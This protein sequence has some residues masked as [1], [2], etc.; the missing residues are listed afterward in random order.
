MRASARATA[1]ARLL[2]ALALGV[3]G[4]GARPSTKYHAPTFD[5]GTI[6]VGSEDALVSCPPTRATQVRALIGPDVS[7]RVVCGT[8]AVTEVPLATVDVEG[9]GTTSWSATLDPDDAFHLPR[10]SFDTCLLSSPTLAEVLLTVPPTAGPGATFDAVATV[11]SDDGS[12]ASGQVNLHAEAVAPEYT[13]DRTSVDFGDVFPDQEAVEVV[14]A[15]S[16]FTAAVASPVSL[17]SDHFQFD[18]PAH[19]TL[20]LDHLTTSPVTFSAH[21]PGDY[22][23]TWTWMAGEGSKPACT[24]TKTVA[25]HARVVAPDAGAG[26]A[27]DAG[28]DGDASAADAARTLTP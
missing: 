22:T 2:A 10:S 17:S 19:P 25:L 23:A 16:E 6:D 7:T 24:T 27:G 5:G 12:F 11:R 13:L 21:D 20:R 18:T 28:A 15:T 9:D 26:D 14:E 1:R 3:A 8:S 4:C